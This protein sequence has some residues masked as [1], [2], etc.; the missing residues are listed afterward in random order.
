MR[1]LLTT[2]L[3]LTTLHWSLSMPSSGS[4][5]RLARI[6]LPFGRQS[7]SLARSLESPANLA[8]RVPEDMDFEDE[9]ENIAKRQFDDYGHM[10]FGRN[11][12]S[13][14]DYGHNTKYGK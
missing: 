9:D 7:S 5:Q 4:L 10:R 2:L 8:R 3:F 11:A 6:V 1:Y 14:Q 13:F 12:P